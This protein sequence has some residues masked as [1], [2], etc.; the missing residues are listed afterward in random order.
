[1][2]LLFLVL[3]ML[4]TP[5]FAHEGH[6]MEEGFVHNLFHGLMIVV[7]VLA[8]VQGIRW[9]TKRRQQK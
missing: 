5:A 2:R 6:H 9:W 8:V 1:M 3:S 4:A 7:A